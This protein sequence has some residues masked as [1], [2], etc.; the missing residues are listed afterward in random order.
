MRYQYSRYYIGA[1]KN[2]VFDMQEVLFQLDDVTYVS[3][4]DESMLNDIQQLV[5][6][7][8]SEPYSVFT[9]R[10]FLHNWPDLCICAYVEDKENIDKKKMIATLI[11]KIEEGTEENLTGYIAMLTV[12]QG[13]RKKGIGMTISKMGI[14]RMID[15]VHYLIF[16]L[17]NLSKGCKEIMLETEATNKGAL[18]LYSKLVCIK[19]MGKIPINYIIFFQGF[20]R[21]EKLSRYYLNGGNVHLGLSHF[22]FVN[23]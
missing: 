11:C 2:L 14:H 10:Y 19:F 17:F 8:L 3:Y 18:G 13:Y 16:E 15:K 20:I 7:D 23:R 5:V 4:S 1:Y 9:Y 22:S 21:E 12:D 6:K